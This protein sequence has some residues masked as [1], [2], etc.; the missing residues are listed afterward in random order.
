VSSSD[1][2]TPVIA[3]ASG[4]GGTGKTTVA[5]G[6][7]LASPAPL[8]L[9]DCDVEEP[10]AHLFFPGAPDTTDVIGVPCPQIDPE[11]CD[12]CGECSKLCQFN[13]IVALQSGAMVFPELCHSCGGCALVCPRQAITEVERRVG[14]IETRAVGPVELITGRLD[15]GV[16]MAPPLIRAVQR[17]SRSDLPVILD[18]PPGT[19]CP[20]TTTFAIADRVVLVT[21]PTPFGLHDLTLIVGVVRLLGLPCGVI[22]NRADVGD[23][24][25]HR[26]CQEQSLP[27]L[28]EIPQDRRIAEAQSRGVPAVEAVPELRQALRDLLRAAGDPAR[29]LQHHG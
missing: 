25:V 8:Q 4:K 24:R 19:A 10:N 13:A 2:H 23:D 21:E 29:P 18:A 14:V 26:F 20:V 9:L 17:R 28:L 6:L 3:V 1:R 5:V 27:I 22:I 7:A 11:R 12:G 16:A 15:V